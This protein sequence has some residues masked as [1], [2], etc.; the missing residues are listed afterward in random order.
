MKRRT[1]VQGVAVLP[2]LPYLQHSI[3]YGEAIHD[4]YSVNFPHAKIYTFQGINKPLH[5]LTLGDLQFGVSRV[6]DEYE[7]IKWDWFVRMGYVDKSP[8]GNVSPDNFQSTNAQK[9]YQKVMY[10]T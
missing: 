3:T 8:Y 4:Y 2:A 10:E 1:F 9:L 5:Q 7:M 6:W